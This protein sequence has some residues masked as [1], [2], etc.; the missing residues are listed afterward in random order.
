MNRAVVA[1][2][3]LPLLVSS[4]VACGGHRRHAGRGG[5]AVAGAGNSALAQTADQQA[6][7]ASARRNGA[8]QGEVLQGATYGSGESVEFRVT[9]DQDHCYWFGG[10]ANE[11]IGLYL[12]DPKGH[13][14]ESQTGSPNDV[15][16]EY[17]P[18]TDGVY[19]LESKLWKRGE[20]AVA[21]YSGTKPE[22]VAAVA[23]KE[24][25]GPSMEDLIAKE[26]GATAPGAKQVGTYFEGTVDETTWST[27]LQAGKCYWF[28]AAGQQGKVKKLALYVWDTKNKRITET[29]AESN[30]VNAGH[31]AK[32]TGMYRFQAKVTS[33]GGPYKV[34]VYEKN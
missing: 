28:I 5:A 11:K 6:Q 8:K 9:L 33:G 1:A 2:I 13:R 25:A 19:K 4:V 21:V 22:P 20:L 18:T 16:M 31:C 10:S 26:A 17:C 7:A 14:V 34:A 32:E 15:L 23:P 24:A 29:K 27:S 12:F 3:A 30:V